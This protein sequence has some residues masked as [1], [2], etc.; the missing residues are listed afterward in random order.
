MH[1][2][3]VQVTEFSASNYP[4]QNADT[5]FCNTV[6]HYIGNLTGSY[7]PKVYLDDVC[8]INGQALGPDSFG[9]FDVNGQW[10]RKDITALVPG[11]NGFYLPFEDRYNPGSD[12]FGSNDW[13]AT[14]FSTQDGAGLDVLSDCNKVNYCTLDPLAQKV[15]GA[16]QAVL[17]D[18]LLVHTGSS[19]TTYYS[20]SFGTM[21]VSSGKW[22][23][24]VEATNLQY[25]H[26]GIIDTQHIP[27]AQGGNTQFDLTAGILGYGYNYGNGSKIKSNTSVAYGNSFT[28]GDVIGVALDLDNGKIWWSKNGT[29]QAGGDP[30]AGTNAAYTDLLT[31]MLSAYAPA[32]AEYNSKVAT[33]NFGQRPFSY[34]QPTGYYTLCS[35]NLTV[36]I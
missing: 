26:V 4:A 11:K 8:L 17:S 14:G 36:E 12:Y 6:A 23:W 18:G 28:T 5:S 25:L 2:N 1:I 9:Q 34:T 29:W 19:G 3:G 22:Y 35:D 7:L 16:G 21:A 15:S 24:E 13:A 32:I 31:S 20:E 10:V 27:T 33:V 30:V